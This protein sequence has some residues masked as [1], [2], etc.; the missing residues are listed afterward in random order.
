MGAKKSAGSCENVPSRPKR[1][2][3]SPPIQA[4]APEVLPVAAKT[5]FPSV[6]KPPTAQIP[7]LTPSVAQAVAL[8]GSFT[9]I[10]T[11][12]PW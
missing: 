3:A 7:A 4:V 9:W 2:M 10:A 8:V 11:T 1:K 5:E 6:D 12:Q